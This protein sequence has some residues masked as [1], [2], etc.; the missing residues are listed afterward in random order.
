MSF[1]LLAGRAKG[2]SGRRRLAEIVC[3]AES[4]IRNWKIEN[5]KSRSGCVSIGLGAAAIEPRSLTSFGMT[6]EEVKSGVWRRKVAAT[7]AKIHAEHTPGRPPEF[8]RQI[9]DDVI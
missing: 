1:K 2:A 5:G 8:S 3:K 4:E 6:Q 9:N 7:K